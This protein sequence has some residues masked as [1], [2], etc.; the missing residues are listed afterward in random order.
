MLAAAQ[1]TSSAIFPSIMVNGMAV[2]V[3]IYLNIAPLLV[4]LPNK[5]YM[6]YLNNNEAY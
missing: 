6:L 5:L 1:L 2:P 4:L 3:I